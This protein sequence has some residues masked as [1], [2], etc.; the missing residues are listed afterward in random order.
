MYHFIQSSVD[1]HRGRSHVLAIVTSAAMN[2]ERHVSFQIIVFSEYL[3]RNGIAGSYSSSLFDI[4]HR[5]I[6]SDLPSRVMNKQMRPN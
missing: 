6:F 4:N 1:G 5:N 2:I 3:P